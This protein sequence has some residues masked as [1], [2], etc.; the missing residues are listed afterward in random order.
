MQWSYYLYHLIVQG[1]LKSQNIVKYIS[2]MDLY[3]NNC[4]PL[5]NPL[6]YFVGLMGDWGPILKKG[7]KGAN[8][9]FLCSASILWQIVRMV[10]LQW[11]NDV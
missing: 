9:T 5:P 6:Y 2:W 1:F 7:Q 3:V 8:L 10:Y 11:N 4:L